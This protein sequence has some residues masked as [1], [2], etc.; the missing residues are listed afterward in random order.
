MIIQFVLS[1]A[2]KDQHQ[3]ITCCQVGGDRCSCSWGGHQLGKYLATKVIGVLYAFG[4]YAFYFTMQ[5]DIAPTEHKKFILLFPFTYL[6][7]NLCTF[8]VT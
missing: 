3:R 4:G 5:S 7:A 8:Q 2:T 1:D 6:L